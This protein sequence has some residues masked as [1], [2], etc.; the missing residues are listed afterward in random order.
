MDLALGQL[1]VEAFQDLAAVDI[2]VKVLDLKHY[3]FSLRG[4][5][6][7]ARV[8]PGHDAV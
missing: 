3:D 7:D 5:G 8:K 4:N 6:M 1:E 2:D